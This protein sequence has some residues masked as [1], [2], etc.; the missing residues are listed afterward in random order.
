MYKKIT[1]FYNLE[2]HYQCWS[3]FAS[4]FF[5][6]IIRCINCKSGF[7]QLNGDSASIHFVKG[8]ALPQNLVELKV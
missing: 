4:H 1:L 5:F 8:N 3:V 6:I 2:M 7:T